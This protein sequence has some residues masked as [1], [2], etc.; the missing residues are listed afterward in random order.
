MSNS[1]QDELTKKTIKFLE[2]NNA[3]VVAAPQ[4]T[5]DGRVTAVAWVIEKQEEDH[6][7]STNPS[8]RSE[9]KEGR[10]ETPRPAPK[11]SPRRDAGPDLGA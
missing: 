1:K 6:K 8:P 10:S 9:P 7:E 4:F 5:Q 3:E 11:V 2:E